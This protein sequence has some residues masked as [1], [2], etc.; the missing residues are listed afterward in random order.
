MVFTNNIY[1]KMNERVEC[2]L[3][4][5]ILSDEEHIKIRHTEFHSKARIQGRNTTQGYPTWKKV[6]D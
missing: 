4:G 2:D 1:N 5:M 3:C 6:N